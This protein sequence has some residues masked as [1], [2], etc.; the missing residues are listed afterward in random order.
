MERSARTRRPPSHH[1][2]AMPMGCTQGKSPRVRPRSPERPSCVRPVRPAQATTG[3]GAAR[4]GTIVIPCPM[5]TD[6]RDRAPR[7]QSSWPSPDS[8]LRDGARHASHRRVS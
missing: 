8:P 6:F 1:D 4:R 5:P 2:H 7:C 3:R